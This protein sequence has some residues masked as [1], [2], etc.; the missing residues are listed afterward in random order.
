[1][2]ILSQSHRDGENVSADY[3]EGMSLYNA[4]RPLPSNAS[5]DMRRGFTSAEDIARIAKERHQKAIMANGDK[6]QIEPD[7]DRL[8]A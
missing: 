4:G 3:V 1:M 8:W 7:G 6:G 2:A 5:K